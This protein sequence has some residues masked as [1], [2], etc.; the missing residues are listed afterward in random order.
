MMGR[1]TRAPHD[2]H[3][4]VARV[5][6]YL[7]RGRYADRLGGGAPV[8]LGAVLEYLCAEVLELAGHAARD[9]KKPR[10]A[11]R[12]ILLAVRRDEELDRL[13]GKT[14]IPGAGVVPHIHKV[15]FPRTKAKKNKNRGA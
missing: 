8:Y 11:P 3:F 7:K 2:D 9:N 10:I 4:P 12:H 15:L 13:L 1:R 6:R 5:A 14:V